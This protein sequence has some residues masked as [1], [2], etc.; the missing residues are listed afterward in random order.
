[1]V[2]QS[3]SRA[4]GSGSGK[5]PGTVKLLRKCNPIIEERIKSTITGI[6]KAAREICQVTRGSGTKYEAP[7]AQI[8]QEVKSL[9]SEDPIKIF[10]TSTRIAKILKDFCGLLPGTKEV[11]PAR[12]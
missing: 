11:M 3:G 1:M 8:N 5:A 4:Y 10:K 9:S 2:L 7:G 12:L 6:Q